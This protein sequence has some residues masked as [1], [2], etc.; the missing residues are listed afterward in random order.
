MFI[1]EDCKWNYPN[2]CH[3]T[4]RPNVKLQDG[5]KDFEPRSDEYHIYDKDSTVRKPI[6]KDKSND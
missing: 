1:C 5:C 6:D 3:D 2:S 4:R